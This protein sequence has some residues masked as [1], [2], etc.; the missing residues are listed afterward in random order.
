MRK[1]FLF[2]LCVVA[3][4]CLKAQTQS[5]NEQAEVNQ[6]VNKFFDGIAAL[7]VKM[8]QQYATK[9][10]L[11]LENGAVWNMDTLAAKLSPLKTMNFTRINR[12]EFIR[13]D[14]KGD[15]A[16][17]AYQNTADISVNGRKAN[18]QWL[19]SAVLV[20][21]ENKWKIQL[22]HSTLVKPKAE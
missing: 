15:I 21:E 12:L 11:L 3:T 17:V 20:K 8:M 19:E 6:T 14:I 22:L 10:F 1:S 2:M 9:D 7:D 5:S 4:L 13:T 16:W 18:P